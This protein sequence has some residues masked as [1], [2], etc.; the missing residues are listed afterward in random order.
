MEKNAQ[1]SITIAK[2]NHLGIKSTNH[3]DTT[4]TRKMFL[5][6][7]KKKER[8]EI[9]GFQNTR[10][11]HTKQHQQ[12]LHVR[13]MNRVGG[14]HEREGRILLLGTW[15]TKSGCLAVVL[16]D[17]S[18]QQQLKGVEL[19]SREWG[20]GTRRSLNPTTSVGIM[21]PPKGYLKK[22]EQLGC[23]RCKWML[24]FMKSKDGKD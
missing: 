8:K 16:F 10:S 19:F 6:K 22:R 12:L 17:Q 5:S 11:V 18:H 13:T 15:S 7:G 14:L 9:T 24:R 21:Q 3:I 23:V 4:W 2:R 20:G 1:K